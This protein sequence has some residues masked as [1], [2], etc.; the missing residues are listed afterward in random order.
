MASTARTPTQVIRAPR[1]CDVYNADDE[2]WTAPLRLDDLSAA[3]GLACLRCWLHGPPVR[4]H[5]MAS[6]PRLDAGCPPRPLCIT[7]RL[8]IAPSVEQFSRFT[9]VVT[10]GDAATCRGAAEVTPPHRV[11]PP[12]RA[13]A[14]RPLLCHQHCDGFA[15]AY[16]GVLGARRT[17]KRGAGGGHRRRRALM[18]RGC[19]SRGA[20]APSCAWHDGRHR[21]CVRSCPAPGG[22]GAHQAVR[23]QARVL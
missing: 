1:A 2:F 12:V 21:R 5:A 3:V 4:I 14:L 9:R 7:S 11:A 13:L 19:P 18:D 8:A 16:A 23:A 17:G 10:R 22:A 6:K 15:A 20:A